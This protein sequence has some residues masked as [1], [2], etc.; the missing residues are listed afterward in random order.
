MKNIPWLYLTNVMIIFMVTIYIIILLFFFKML[1]LMLL[2]LLLLKLLN[3]VEK[4]S[5]RLWESKFDGLFSLFKEYIVYR[6]WEI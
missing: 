5:Y 4:S 2:L 6:C 1:L 3:N